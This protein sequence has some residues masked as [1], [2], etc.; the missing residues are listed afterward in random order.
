[1]FYV[2]NICMKSG[3][4]YKTELTIKLDELIEQLMPKTQFSIPIFNCNIFDGNGKSVAI[5]GT[6]VS[7]IEYFVKPKP[8]SWD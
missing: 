4:E 1:M 5:I 2:Y 7:S 8:N 6:E 3:K